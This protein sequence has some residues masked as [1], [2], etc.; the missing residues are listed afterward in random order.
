VLSYNQPTWDAAIGVR[1]IFDAAYFPTAL[2]AGGHVGQP[3]FF[4]VQAKYHL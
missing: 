2:S 4:F 1:N 3:Q